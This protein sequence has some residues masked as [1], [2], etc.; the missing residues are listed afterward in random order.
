MTLNETL[1]QFQQQLNECRTHSML[2]TNGWQILKPYISDPL[3]VL[4][5]LYST[6]E[7]WIPSMNHDYQHRK[8]CTKELVN[9]LINTLCKNYKLQSDKVLSALLMV[10]NNCVFN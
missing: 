6:N 10:S 5:E 8:L 7:L 4:R 1:K 2:C 3:I 9:A